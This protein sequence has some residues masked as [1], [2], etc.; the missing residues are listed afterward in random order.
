[1]I[2]KPSQKIALGGGCYWCTEAVFQTLDGVENVEQ[3]FVAPEESNATYSEAVIVHFNHALISLKDLIEIHLHT[4]QSTSAH[5][6][7]SKYRSAIYTFSKKQHDEA[8]SIIEIFQDE[9][10]NGLITKVLPFGSFEAS[11]EQFRNY[12]YNNPQKPFCEKYITPKLKVLRSCFPEN[13]R[14]TKTEHL[15]C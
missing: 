10:A 9:F 2:D 6:M 14:L 15:K 12:Y 3:G 11:N 13:V 5:S 1:M 7:R 4:H 8:M